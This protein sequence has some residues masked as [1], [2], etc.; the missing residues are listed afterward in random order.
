VVKP[1]APPTVAAPEPPVDQPVEAAPPVA[2]PVAPEPA[3]SPAPPFHPCDKSCVAADRAAL[4]AGIRPRT[5]LAPPELLRGCARVSAD[6]RS[7]GIHRHP[8]ETA[9]PQ[10][11]DIPP[12]DAGRRDRNAVR[13]AAV[14]ALV[15]Q[16]R[17]TD[18]DLRCHPIIARPASASSAGFNKQGSQAGAIGLGLDGERARREV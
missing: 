16:N 10:T 17:E 8:G 4:N 15:I 12:P 9:T 6:P 7:R 2:E 14:S 3:P 5:A 13:R 11:T 18:R 1:E